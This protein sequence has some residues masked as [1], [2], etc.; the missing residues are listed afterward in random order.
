[1]LHKKEKLE[2]RYGR[3]DPKDDTYLALLMKGLN[4]EDTEDTED[5][6]FRITAT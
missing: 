5:I 4:S 3:L 2:E 1:M 6:D